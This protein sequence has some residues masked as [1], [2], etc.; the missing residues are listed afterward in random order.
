MPAIRTARIWQGDAARWDVQFSFSLYDQLDEALST[1]SIDAGISVCTVYIRDTGM[2][3]DH[4]SLPPDLDPV[5]LS[6]RW[7]LDGELHCHMALN[8]VHVS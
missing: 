2:R 6:L 8:A 4:L 3:L 1:Y 5:D 7:E